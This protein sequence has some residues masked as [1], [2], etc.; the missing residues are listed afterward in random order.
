MKM[1]TGNVQMTRYVHDTTGQVEYR[2]RW[3]AEIEAVA[4]AAAA[5]RGLDTSTMIGQAVYAAIA[6]Q[7]PTADDE[8]KH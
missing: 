1:I 7:M 6:E 3:T 2:L 4:V 5:R 8:V